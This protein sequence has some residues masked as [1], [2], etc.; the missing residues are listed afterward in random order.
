MAKF[1]A[2]KKAKIGD[3]RNRL[4]Y[5]LRFVRQ[6]QSVMVFDRDRAIARIDPVRDV[7]PLGDADAWPTDLVQTGILLPPLARLG[8]DWLRR[9]PKCRTDVV[10]ALL[11]ERASAR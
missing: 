8:R 7:A 10:N 9:R 2:M 4:S 6:G 5:F 1:I 11:E 3:L